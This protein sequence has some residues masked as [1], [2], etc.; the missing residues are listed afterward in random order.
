MIR[1][2]S[3]RNLNLS[4]ATLIRDRNAIVRPQQLAFDTKLLGRFDV[5]LLLSWA[6]ISMLGYITLLFHCLS[7][8]LSRAQATQITAFLNL[9]TAFGR[10]F[11]GVA[12]D[13]LGR[14]EIAGVLTL[15]CGLCSC[16]TFPLVPVPRRLFPRSRVLL[17]DSYAG[18]MR[19]RMGGINARG[20]VANKA[21]MHILSS[22]VQSNLEPSVGS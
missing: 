21:Y 4:A 18:L 3:A 14:I 9:G 6:F 19:S 16:V 13:R 1:S 20:W 8:G 15:V 5:L 22:L 7:I 2:Y 11:I 12:S 10:P 17:R